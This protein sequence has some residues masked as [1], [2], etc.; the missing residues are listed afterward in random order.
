MAASADQAENLSR[1]IGEGEMK[2]DRSAPDRP[3]E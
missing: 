1:D 3:G 2:Q